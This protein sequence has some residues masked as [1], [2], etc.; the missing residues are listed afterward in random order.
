MPLSGCG[1]PL[2]PCSAEDACTPVA[3]TTVPGAQIP[4]RSKRRRRRPITCRKSRKPAYRK[5]ANPGK[6]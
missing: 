2:N 5:A 6:S 4:A 3:H 1:I